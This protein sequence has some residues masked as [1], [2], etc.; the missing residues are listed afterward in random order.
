[1]DKT[2]SDAD[3]L[4]K[5]AASLEKVPME[6]K[7]MIYEMSNSM[8]K[9]EIV[10]SFNQAAIDFFTLLIRISDKIGKKDI[11]DVSGYKNLFEHALK[12][13]IGLPIDKFT[14]TIL[15]FAKYIYARDE[16]GILSMDIAD[17]KVGVDNEFSVIKSKMFK[18]LW[19]TLCTDDRNEIIDSLVLLTSFAHTFL[20][21]S[22]KTA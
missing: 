17:K 3:Q 18:D 5:V 15:E 8:P 22:L 21:H 6:T 1:M 14:L 16:V 20:Y 11:C 7:Q 9:A 2:K 4:V 19:V 12:I 13:N 10:Q